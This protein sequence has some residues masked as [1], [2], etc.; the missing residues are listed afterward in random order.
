MIHEAGVRILFFVCL[1]YNSIHLFLAILG[2]HCCVALT[3][4]VASRGC[5]SF[6]RCSWCGAP[7]LGAQ[8]STVGAPRL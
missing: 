7:A 6:Q 4:V 1:F 5:S 2:L 3:L 8:A